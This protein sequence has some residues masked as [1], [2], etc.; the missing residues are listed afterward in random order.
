MKG[1]GGWV[2]GEARDGAPR[3]CN[4]SKDRKMKRG[5]FK[6]SPTKRARGRSTEL[7]P[8]S[9]N[10]EGT[11][12]AA[13]TIQATGISTSRTAAACPHPTLLALRFHVS[14]NDIRHRPR[15]YST[16]QN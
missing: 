1:Q 16:A 4:A 12:H 5:R 7:C 8:S 2:P 10:L 15:V 14:A 13:E 6:Q 11:V 9:E 3:P